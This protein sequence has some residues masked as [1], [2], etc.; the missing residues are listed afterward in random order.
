M[1]DAD[2]HEA[3]GR[4]PPAPRQR[5]NTLGYGGDVASVDRPAR[6]VALDRIFRRRVLL[7]VAIPVS[8]W[9]SG[10]TAS[11]R[12]AI[13]LVIRPGSSPCPCRCRPNF[14]N[15]TGPSP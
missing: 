8:V 6:P 13:A 7:E 1:K 3:S 2:K 9:M 14:W 4:V 15:Q 12:V 5:G 11:A 10:S